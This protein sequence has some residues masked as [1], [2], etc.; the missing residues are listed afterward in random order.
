MAVFAGLVLIAVS[1]SV[2]GCELDDE[3]YEESFEPN[4]ML[5]GEWR[6]EWDG[7]IIN[8]GAT[9]LEYVDGGYGVGFDGTIVKVV[10]FNSVRTAGIIF[11]KYG[12]KPVDYSTGV[13]PEGDYIGIYFKDLTSA[14]GQFA[15]PV[16]EYDS[17][18]YLTPAK[19]T[20]AEAEQTFTEGKA[21]DYVLSWV[22]YEK[23][24]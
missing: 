6:T 16:E 23:Q 7:Y 15:S 4:P 24:Q 8:L 5:E 10:N 2:T 9:T 11:I 1:L 13:P 21:G 14:T 12:N 19:A 17:D 3:E 22:T 18:T 20:Q